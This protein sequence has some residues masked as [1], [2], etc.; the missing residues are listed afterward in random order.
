MAVTKTPA[1][2]GLDH[3]VV[4]ADRCWSD[5]G[6]RHDIVEWCRTHLGERGSGSWDIVTR[7]RGLAMVPVIR[8]SNREHHVLATL[9]WG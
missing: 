3:E 6:T 7:P 1:G 2:T 4:V 8:V 5:R 9:A